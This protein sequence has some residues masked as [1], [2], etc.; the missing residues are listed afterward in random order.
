MAHDLELKHDCL[1]DMIVVDDR[2]LS[3]ARGTAPIY[4]KVRAEGAA[5]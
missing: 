2:D 5:I 1:I 4:E 3:G